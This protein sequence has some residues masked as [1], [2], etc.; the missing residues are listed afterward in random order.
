MIHKFTQNGYYI[1]LDVNSGAVFELDRCA[2]EMLDYIKP[3][4][5][6]ECPQELYNLL[7]DFPEETVKETYGEIKELIDRRI[8]FST[9]DYEPF[10]E[11]LGTAPV[12]SMCLNIAHNCNLRCGYCFAS[13]GDFGHGKKLMSYE[14]GKKAIDFLVA[15]SA[16][17]K[18]LEVDFF[19]GEPLMNFDTVKR[20]V[21][22]ARSL[23]KEHNKNFRFTIT[24]NGLL[25]DK[26]KID[27]INK[28]MSNV[29]LSIDGR[30]EINDRYRINAQ[31]AGC[32]ETIVP[33]FKQLVEERGDKEY[34]VRGTYTRHNT[35]FSKDVEHLFSLGF[36][37]VSIEPA[38]TDEDYEYSITEKELPAIFEE[39]E[40]L[41]KIMLEHK[42]KGDKLNFFHFMLDLDQGPCVYKRLRGCS[43]GNE[44]IA[45]T[46]EGDIYP[47]HQFVGIDEKKMGSVLDGSF[48]QELKEDFATAT[49]YSKEECKNCWAKFYCSGGCNANNYLYEGS[50][51]KPHK[52]SCEIE[53]KRLE[54]AI[55]IKV[56]LDE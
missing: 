29:V 40:H 22:Y 14:V 15:S 48:N 51:R 50:I 47:C 55:M 23:E 34:Y 3:G 39:Y 30:Q 19:G 25:L 43:C 7:R 17:R 5:A 56:A 6:D 35:D 49:V 44:Y 10:V 45:V 11:S 33:K 53:R 26:D 1:V 52:I 36:D 27:F 38:V 20:L 31:G 21:A 9:D 4:I 54:C 46:P 2:Y 42:R 32:Y 12:K 24:T 37:Q 16:G 13:Q 8:L 28:E 41:A 18:N